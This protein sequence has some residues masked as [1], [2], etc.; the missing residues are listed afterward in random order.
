[1]DVGTLG[2]RGS[3]PFSCIGQVGRGAWRM[4]RGGT[5]PPESAER[6]GRCI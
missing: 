2:L 4:R 1:M 6:G 5:M 3:R